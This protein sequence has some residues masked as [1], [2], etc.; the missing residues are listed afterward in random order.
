MCYDERSVFLCFS[1][2]E[3]NQHNKRKRSTAAA[4]RARLNAVGV[5]QRPLRWITAKK[6]RRKRGSADLQH[7]KSKVGANWSRH[8]S[9]FNHDIAFRGCLAVFHEN[10]RA[11]LPLTS[12]SITQM[13]KFS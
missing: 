9:K 1:K 3:A 8:A 10:L 2:N 13:K 11:S 7:K 4:R 12:I 6:W 5:E